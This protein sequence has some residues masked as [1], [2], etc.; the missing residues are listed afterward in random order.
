MER[1]TLINLLLYCLLVFKVYY[2]SLECLLN[3]FF[4]SCASL[5]NSNLQTL[6]NAKL[7]YFVYITAGDEPQVFKLQL[8]H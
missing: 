5:P 7:T 1:P 8:A 4:V 6:E 3:K 2:S